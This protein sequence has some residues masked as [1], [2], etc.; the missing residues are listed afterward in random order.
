LLDEYKDVVEQQEVILHLLALLGL[1]LGAVIHQD[2]GDGE[3]RLQHQAA[4]EG[5]QVEQA[6]T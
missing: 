5:E 4:M 2:E 6:C 3:H 1:A